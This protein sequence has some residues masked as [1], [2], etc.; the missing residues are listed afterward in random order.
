MCL[1]N[2]IKA[3]NH[4]KETNLRRTVL[5]N[6]NYNND[7]IDNTNNNN[8]NNNKTTKRQLLF[9]NIATYLKVNNLNIKML[10]CN[11]PLSQRKPSSQVS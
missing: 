9:V 5:N 10:H 4:V 11:L 6:I 7:N 3:F 2:E 1:G 8:N